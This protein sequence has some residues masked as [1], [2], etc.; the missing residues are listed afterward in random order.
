MLNS[1][2]TNK[3]FLCL[4]LENAFEVIFQL[5]VHSSHFANYIYDNRESIKICIK[6]KSKKILH[7]WHDNSRDDSMHEF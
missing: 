2:F 3:I 6:N 7:N 5:L 4:F 1:T